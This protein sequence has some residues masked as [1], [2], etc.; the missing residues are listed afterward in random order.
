MSFQNPYGFNAATS[1]TLIESHHSVLIKKAVTRNAERESFRVFITFNLLNSNP[2]TL[3][4]KPEQ[5]AI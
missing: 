4:K 5:Y 3:G 1:L 2:V